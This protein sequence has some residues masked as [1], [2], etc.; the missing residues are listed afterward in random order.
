LF[1]P[2]VRCTGACTG[3]QFPDPLFPGHAAV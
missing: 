3:T 1:T 2:Y